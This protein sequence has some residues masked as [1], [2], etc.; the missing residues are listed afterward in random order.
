M[1][2]IP[3][4]QPQTG[5]W[6]EP[7]TPCYW[8][9]LPIDFPN[10]KFKQLVL[11]VDFGHLIS[12]EGWLSQYFCIFRRTVLQM[13]NIVAAFGKVFVVPNINK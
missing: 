9:V 7:S 4:H 12:L 1:D 6:P 10:E 13:E 8:D 3:F 11:R 2:P 5:D